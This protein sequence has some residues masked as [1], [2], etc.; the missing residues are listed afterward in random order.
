MT[1]RPCWLEDDVVP[2]EDDRDNGMMQHARG[3]AAGLKHNAAECRTMSAMSRGGN[4][5]R[6]A[7]DAGS[8]DHNCSMAGFD[9]MFDGP[10]FVR[11]TQTA[12]LKNARP[13]VWPVS[14][15]EM[16][17]H[18]DYT[19]ECMDTARSDTTTFSFLQRRPQDTRAARST[20]KQAPVRRQAVNSVG[21]G[22]GVNHFTESEGADDAAFEYQM[23]GLPACS[24]VSGQRMIDAICPSDYGR[25]SFTSEHRAMGVDRSSHRD[26]FEPPNSG[27]RNGRDD[28]RS[29][30][31]MA[32]SAR[33]DRTPHRSTFT[34]MPARVD[35]TPHRSTF[36]P[37]PARVDRTPHRSTFTP[38]R[39]DRTPHRNA[40]TPARVD[41]TPH[42]NAFTPDPAH[43]TGN[44]IE[45]SNDA[46]FAYRTRS[47]VP[48]KRTSSVTAMTTSRKW[49][50]NDSHTR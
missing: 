43:A 12:Q 33:V 36:T 15:S 39:V 22:F 16:R 1:A 49:S 11:Q 31:T 3:K 42:R 13:E 30:F 35:R 32:Q 6:G 21:Y 48:A 44:L 47:C 25:D 2:A 4:T 24:S 7:P 18:T 5:R 8:S 26:A 37:M 50:W 19:A 40:F 29:S 27:I 14:T 20:S 17:G 41:R 34:P 23:H 28:P 45:D 9:S 10:T 46:A 38:A